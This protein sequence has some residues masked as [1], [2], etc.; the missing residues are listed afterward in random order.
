MASMNKTKGI[1]F[2][3]DNTLLQ[4]KID[5]A[6]MKL[7][8]YDFLGRFKLLPHDFPVQEHTT[9]TMI[10]C[11]KKSGMTSETYEAAMKITEKHELKGME[12]AGLE[13]GVMDLIESLHTKYILVIVTN[14][15][16]TA[17]LKALEK[18]EVRKYF[19]FIIGREQMTSLKPSPS[20]YLV[21]KSQFKHI[22]SDEW[23]AIGDSWIDGRAS[24]DAGIPFIC[25]KT[26]CEEML[27]K[28][29]NPIGRVNNII[30]M[31]DFIR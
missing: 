3:M 26:S 6:A 20:G 5:F 24:I 10:E 13:P 29:V 22:L 19:D 15:S 14:N 17:A 12:G 7:D 23:I 2:D 21:A 11:A 25:Y 1:I 30:E 18:T 27:N 31:L 4:S 8:V 28:G 9:S 16:R